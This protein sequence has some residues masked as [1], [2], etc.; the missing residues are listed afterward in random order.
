M[1]MLVLISGLTVSGLGWP[2]VPVPASP[3]AW[4]LVLGG[5]ILL[6]L[7]LGLVVQVAAA[8]ANGMS[9]AAGQAM[10]LGFA[11]SVDPSTGQQGVI[12]DRLLVLMLLVLALVM[13]VHLF[14]I[15]ALAQT[16]R[17]IPVGTALSLDFTAWPVAERGQHLFWASLRLG[18]PVMAVSLMVQVALAVLAR[19]VPQMNLLSLG[20]TISLPVGLL[21]LFLTSQV[22]WTIWQDELGQ[23]GQVIVDVAAQLKR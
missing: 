22:T 13:D 21:C 10:G 18:A 19:V 20:L 15:E 9:Q 6:G 17:A 1:G 2:S 23:L 8:M 7:A 4:V 12:L 14:V 11:V 16:F 3:L 5:E